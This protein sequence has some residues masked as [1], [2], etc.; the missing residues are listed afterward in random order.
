MLHRTVEL[1][2]DK[3]ERRP[4][5]PAKKMGPAFVT[6]CLNEGLIARAMPHGDILG[7][8]PQLTLSRSEADQIV[9]KAIKALATVI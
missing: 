9:D 6:A 4:F 1:A 7:F 5:D 3:D 2:E 8:A